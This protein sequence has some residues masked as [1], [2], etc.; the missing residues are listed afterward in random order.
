MASRKIYIT[1]FVPKFPK[2][3]VVSHSVSC[4]ILSA[5]FRKKHISKIAQDFIYLQSRKDKLVTL[6]STVRVCPMSLMA[7]RKVSVHLSLMRSN[8]ISLKSVLFYSSSPTLST[9]FFKSF[10]SFHATF[11][12]W[13]SFFFCSCV[14]M[15]SAC[16]NYYY[17]SFF[18]NKISFMGTRENSMPHEAF[19]IDIKSSPGCICI[20]QV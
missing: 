13:M 4:F 11:L 16:S 19:F 14:A 17:C 6:V 12:P 2:A 5:V 7:H 18:Y 10:C 9:Y 20:S 15:F 8:W 1:F 3:A